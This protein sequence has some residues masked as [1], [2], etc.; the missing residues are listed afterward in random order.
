MQFCV[1]IRSTVLLGFP[2]KSRCYFFNKTQFEDKD[3]CQKIP[4]E[5]LAF[6]FHAKLFEFPVF[7]SGVARQMKSDN[8]VANSRDLCNAK[9][10]GGL[11]GTQEQVGSLFA[12][13]QVLALENSSTV[14]K[15]SRQ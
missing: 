5:F 7:V 2:F 3:I 12:K 13:K 11:I 14:F 6:Q 10:S 4:D 8:G 15:S 9:I 1:C